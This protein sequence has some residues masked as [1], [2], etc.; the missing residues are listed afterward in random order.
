MALA[1]LNLLAE[2]PIFPIVKD[3]TINAKTD[4]YKAFFN[5]NFTSFQLS[6][7]NLLISLINYSC[8]KN[9]KSLSA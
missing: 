2:Y 6:I 1:L 8:S 5:F 7:D 9:T 3:N 4:K